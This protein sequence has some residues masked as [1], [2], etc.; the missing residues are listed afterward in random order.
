MADEAKTELSPKAAE[1]PVLASDR[2]V[3]SVN[4]PKDATIFNAAER[5]QVATDK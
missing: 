2:V 5:G 1:M 3:E 4:K